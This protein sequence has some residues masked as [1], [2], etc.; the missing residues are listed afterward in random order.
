MT[1]QVRFGQS[2]RLDNGLLMVSFAKKFISAVYA[3]DVVVYAKQHSESA[4][5]H[6]LHCFC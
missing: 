2:A 4:R 5:G 6:V 1:K 3:C